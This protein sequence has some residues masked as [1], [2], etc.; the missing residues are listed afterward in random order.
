MDK[1]T[2][3]ILKTKNPTEL[4]KLRLL[5]VKEIPSQKILKE[6]QRAYK[7]RERSLKRTP[8]DKREDWVEEHPETYYKPEIKQ[9]E[10]IPDWSN[11]ELQTELGEIDYEEYH[12]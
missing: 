10:E 7:K 2:E 1:V 8:I 5:I 4:N 6:R 12:S 3:A 11:R 9:Y